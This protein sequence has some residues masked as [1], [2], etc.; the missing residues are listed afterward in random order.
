MGWSRVL[1]SRT[2]VAVAMSCLATASCTS[3]TAGSGDESGSV[4]PS[5]RPSSAPAPSGSPAI[6]RSATLRCADHIATPD[7]PAGD[8]QVI[9][10]AVALPTAAS[11]GPLQASAD[12]GRSRS[13]LFAKRG[14][15]VR[16][17]RSVDLVVPQNERHRLVL[18]WGKPGKL[19]WRLHVSCP[20]SYAKWLA[21]PG[22]YYV[23]SRNC[24][25]LIVRSADHDDHRV[26]IGI[27]AHC[28]H[29]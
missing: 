21:F 13:W 26:E 15:L 24:V 9:E 2:M 8:L 18:Q 11:S 29:D 14:L 7:S 6:V 1:R 12:G 19:T 3:K 23:S 4:S 17:G 27:G 16:T 22:G 28:A 10:D 25:S 5:A 20:H